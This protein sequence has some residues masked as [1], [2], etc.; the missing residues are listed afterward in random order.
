MEKKEPYPHLKDE[1]TKQER[2]LACQTHG[3]QWHSPLSALCTTLFFPGLALR[4]ARCQDQ[5]GSQEQEVEESSVTLNLAKSPLVIQTRGL[6]QG[7]AELWLGVG[8]QEEREGSHSVK[9]GDNSTPFRE[10]DK[11]NSVRN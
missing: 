4:R 8:S 5:G 1:E 10:R 3:A 9:S 2:Q 6:S 11:N 7:C